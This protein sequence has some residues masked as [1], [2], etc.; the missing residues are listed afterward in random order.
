MDN[1]KTLRTVDEAASDVQKK[2]DSAQI[3]ADLHAIGED[4]QRLARHTGEY[5]SHE[6]DQVRA[7]AGRVYQ[8]ARTRGEGYY[9]DARDASAQA[10]DSTIA[11]VRENPG[12]A[13]AIAF[14][15]GLVTSFLFGR[16]H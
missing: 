5:I 8:D 9:N 1:N 14:L 15:A 12:Q 3:K 7:R 2:A 6:S 4:A 11:R 16:K 13:V 10:Y